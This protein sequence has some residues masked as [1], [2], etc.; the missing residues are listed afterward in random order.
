MKALDQILSEISCI[1]GKVWQMEQELSEDNVPCR[2]GLIG[3]ENN[4]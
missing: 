2:K 3:E 4:L 1:Q